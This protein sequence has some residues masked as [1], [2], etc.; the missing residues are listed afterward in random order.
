MARRFGQ[1]FG[2]EPRFAR[3]DPTNTIEQGYATAMRTVSRPRV[4]SPIQTVQSFSS[5]TITGTLSLADGTEAAPSFN[6]TGDTDTG[7]RRAGANDWRLVSGAADVLQLSSAGITVHN[8]AVLLENND[9]GALGVSGTAFSDLFLASG[10][11]I[12]FNAADVTLTH[13]SNILTIGGGDLLVADTFG[14]VIGHTAQV[15]F[16]ATPEFQV[17]GTGTADASMGFARFQS[18]TSGPDIRFLKSRGTT[19]G[20]NVIVQSGDTIGRIRFQAADGNDFN[21]PAVEITAQI[22]GTPGLNDM[23][24]RL[25]FR[26]T[27]DGASSVTTRLIID[28]AGNSDFQSN[29]ISSVG[30]L[31][32]TTLAGT[33][34]TAAQPNITSFGTLAILEID[35]IR[36]N[37]NTI[38]STAGTDLFITPLTGQQLILDGTI[39]I[40]AGVLTGGTSFTVTT[41]VGALTG[42]A[43]T[44]SSAAVLTTARTI[45]TVSF[46]GSANITVTAAAGTLTG[47]T[48]NSSVTA[49]SLTSVGV[50]NSGSVT[51]G[52]GS[53]DVGTSAIDGGTITAA[54]ALAGTLSTAAQTNI[55]SIGT[56]TALQVDNIRINGNTIDSTA[57][58][59]LNITPLAGQQIVLDGTIVIDA[60]VVTGIT[61]LTSSNLLASSDN[62]GAIGASGTGFSDLFL[63]SGSVI[64]FAAGD[65][66]LTHSSNVLAIAGGDLSLDGDLDFVGAQAI[67]T[68]AGDLTLNPAGDVVIS[69][70][71]TVSGTGPHAIGNAT[72]DYIGMRMGGSFTS[73]GAATTAEGLRV[74]Y[75][76]VGHSGDS[77]FHA[78]YTSGG[79][80]G[81]SIE[82]N[83]NTTDVA[84][85]LLFEPD[86]T[87]TAGSVTNASTLK[88]ANAPSE[89]TNNYAL[90]VD[91]GVTRLDGLIRGAVSSADSLN[92]ANGISNV[93]LVARNSLVFGVDDDN[94]GTN[95]NFTW[96]HNGATELMRFT[97][98]GLLLVGDTVNANMT[99]GLT[100][101]QGASDNQILALKSSDIG[102]VLTTITDPDVETDDYCVMSKTNALEGGLHLL[103]LAEDAAVG[104]TLLI[105]AWGG[106]G[107]TT[108]TSGGR[109]LMEMVAVEHNGA[110]VHAAP[111]ADGNIFGIRVNSN[112]AGLLATRF[113]VDEDGDVFTTT[114]VDVTATGNAVAATA[115]DEYDDAL[116]V[117]A[118]DTARTPAAIIRSEWDEHVRYN[119]Q[120]LIDADILGAPISE[121]GLTNITQLQRLHNGAIWQ[122]YVDRQELH[123]EQQELKNRLEVIE[124]KL[125]A[126]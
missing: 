122:A 95:L 43:D 18:N 92:L 40:D 54:T 93:E 96:Q 67:T 79:T 73:G 50:L 45:N 72:V 119:E 4:I 60:G 75:D 85:M 118:L 113:M 30:T 31:T 106:T 90:W 82:T 100:I 15:D 5:V 12:N 32:A 61:S 20:S 64:N 49:S 21:T 70:N 126:A 51:S 115:F 121:G 41:F 3:V 8:G 111:T 42:N 71:L 38:D 28:A 86:I 17:L 81:A 22:D 108:K 36:L 78:L 98:A 57:G 59:D 99:V 13:S 109:S 101:N 16:G 44:A 65:V 84:T 27:A 9:G 114:V 123:Q 52:F 1:V 89:G 34:S 66:T 14:V 37:G 124:Q 46:D 68:T 88:I 6:F 69:D 77:L 112:A 56:L 7:I 2:D 62:S 97:D 63:A 23:P 117:R 91:T 24:G 104:T 87:E 105:E 48:I 25:L 55:T 116:L 47:A 11:V 29:D 125:L 10:A 107:T 76:L 103:S 33:L 53:I 39:I 58:V 94:N 120:S 110:N 74:D 19:I 35:N 102:T 26:T 80:V 83:G